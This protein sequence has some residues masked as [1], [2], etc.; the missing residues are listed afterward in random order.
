MT[1][2]NEI[3]AVEEVL[4]I[5]EDWLT[6]RIVK[7]T[8]EWGGEEPILI[9]SME[10]AFDY[11]DLGEHGEGMPQTYD[12][13][14]SSLQEELPQISILIDEDDLEINLEEDAIEILSGEFF[15]RL[16]RVNPV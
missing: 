5:F 7:A 4:P 14:F 16:T 10:G 13:F 12:F 11:C 3:T 9:C 1:E 15:L 8:L 6:D 2:L